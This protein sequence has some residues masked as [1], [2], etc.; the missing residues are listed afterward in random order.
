MGVA[1][2]PGPSTRI[3]VANATSWRASW[4]GLLAAGADVYC[5]QEARVP[6]DAGSAAAAVA[7]ARRRGLRLQLG[8]AGEGTHLLAFAHREGLHSLRAVQMDG[9]TPEQACRLQYAVVYLHAPSTEARLESTS[10]G[11]HP[12]GQAELEHK[13]KDIREYPTQQQKC[14]QNSE[15]A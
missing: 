8:A 15:Q 9:L 12:R 1:A 11:G 10:A 14:A 4:R 6:E 3:L 7:E 13:P 2:H 5:I